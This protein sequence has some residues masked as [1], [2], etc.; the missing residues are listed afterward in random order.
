MQWRLVRLDLAATNPGV[1]LYLAPRCVE[2]IANGHVDVFMSLLVVGCTADND[3][4][5]GDTY[6]D[7]NVVELAFVLVFMG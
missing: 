4:P 3:F 2:R 6:V 7:D 1:V 5:A